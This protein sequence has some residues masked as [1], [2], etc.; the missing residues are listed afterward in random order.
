M[1]V[2]GEVK[3]KQ[4]GEWSSG[5]TL[6]L[7]RF[8]D[9][10]DKVVDIVVLGEFSGASKDLALLRFDIDYLSNESLH[11]SAGEKGVVLFL[12]HLP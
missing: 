12:S 2:R 7:Q 3:W 4:M 5:S 1:R 9:K 11:A 10:L 6:K 8:D